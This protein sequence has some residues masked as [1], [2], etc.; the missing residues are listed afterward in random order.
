MSSDFI[1]MAL[2]HSLADVV[3]RSSDYVRDCLVQVFGQFCQHAPRK[4]H[5]YLSS[6]VSVGHK[7]F[8]VAVTLSNTHVFGQVQFYFRLA[9]NMSIL[10]IKE[11]EG[12][13]GC[14]TYLLDF[15]SGKL[16]FKVVIILQS[17]LCISVIW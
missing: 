12:V 17:Q 1:E 9:G 14:G 16:S 6:E 10:I 3:G 15:C 8:A 11:L 2:A 5:R 7:S 13:E 4:Y